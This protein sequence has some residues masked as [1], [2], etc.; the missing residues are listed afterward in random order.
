ME[1]IKVEDGDS[2]IEVR[3]TRPMWLQLNQIWKD[4]PDDENVIFIHRDQ[5]ESLIKVLKDFT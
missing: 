2:I 3:L 5:V 1:V 4:D